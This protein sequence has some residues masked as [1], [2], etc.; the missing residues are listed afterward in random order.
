[1]LL[2]NFELGYKLRETDQKEEKI[3]KEFEL[4]E[5]NNWD[6]SQNVVFLIFDTVIWISAWNCLSIHV[7]CTF[8]YRNVENEFMSF[9]S[10]ETTN[11]K[12]FLNP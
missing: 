11:P 4:I 10:L 12:N 8:L 6:E 2:T 7:K 3:E 1:M 5:Q 9:T